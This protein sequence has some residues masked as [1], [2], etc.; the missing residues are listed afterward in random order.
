MKIHWWGWINRDESSI[1]ELCLK[2]DHAW[3]VFALYLRL[4][5]KKIGIAPRW[6]F[7]YM[8]KY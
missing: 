8:W 4:R 3:N 7:D 5:S 1:F 6:V 2:L